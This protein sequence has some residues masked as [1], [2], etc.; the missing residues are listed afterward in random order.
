MQEAGLCQWIPTHQATEYEIKYGPNYEG[1]VLEIPV[2]TKEYS[3]L[4]ASR[5][6]KRQ[7]VSQLWARMTAYP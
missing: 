5:W 2:G 1:G 3:T 6:S 4:T 7:P